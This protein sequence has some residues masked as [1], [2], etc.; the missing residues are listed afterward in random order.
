MAARQ[1]AR[2]ERLAEQVREFVVPRGDERAID[3]GTG[4]G[5]L[6][7]A[8]APLVREVVGVDPVPELL[9]LARERAAACA[10]V[11]FLEA[12]GTALPF[13][14]GSFDL[15]GTQRTLHHVERPG[16]V[17]SELARVTRPGGR[18][19]VVDQ[20]APDDPERADALHAFERAR[21]PSHQ[22]LLTDA[23]LRTL[24]A[25]HGLELL[26]DR[27]EEE[28][29]RLDAYLDLAGCAGEPR[30][31]AESLAAAAGAERATVGWYLL[32][33]AC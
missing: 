9:A 13:P 16:Q 30:A 20:L 31:R 6:A 3:V 33:R 29:R 1:D 21:D 19:L 15:A 14:D 11:E 12:D 25:A 17:V 5:A 18:V 23:E 7:L 4:A 24:F 2:A 28:R 32:E 8:L 22:R 26:R 27:R 10:H